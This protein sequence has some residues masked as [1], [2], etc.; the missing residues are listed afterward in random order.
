VKEV[1]MEMFMD[2]DELAKT[3]GIPGSTVDHLRKTGK[4]PFYKIGK[5]CRYVLAEVMKFFKDQGR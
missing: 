4:I 5:H 2:R 1:N 3:L